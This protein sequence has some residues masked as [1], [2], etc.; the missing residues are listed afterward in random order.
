MIDFLQVIAIIT[1]LSGV[2]LYGRKHPYGPL[3]SFLGCVICGW[4]TLL[5]HLPWLTLLNI[6][7][8]AM[9]FINIMKWSKNDAIF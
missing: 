3:V 6:V 7:M 1:V 8:G 2:Y 5:S 9:H 4:I